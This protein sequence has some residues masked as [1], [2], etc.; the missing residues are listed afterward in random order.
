MQKGKLAAL[1]GVAVGVLA[2]VAAA[3]LAV[4]TPSKPYT[5]GIAEGYVT[6]PLLTV[7]DTVPETSDPSKQYQ[8]VGIPDGLGARPNP[9]PT[10]TVW[11]NHELVHNTLSRTTIGE[12]RDRGPIVSKYI[13]DSN[14][15]PISGERAYDEVYLENTFVGPAPTEANRTP[16]FTRFCSASLAGKAEGLDTDIYFANE[17]SGGANTFDGLGGLAVAITG[18]KAYGLPKLGHFAWENTLVQ[19][20]RRGKQVAM[21]GLED[22]PADLNP[23]NVNSQVYLYVGTKVKGSSSVLSRNG[24]DNGKLYVLAPVNPAVS[25]E[26]SFANGTIDVK[27]VQVPNSNTTE[28]C[29]ARGGQRRRRRVPLRAAR[30][31]GSTRRTPTTSSS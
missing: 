15:T 25:S 8:M 24:L 13:L 5:V 9:G 17:E 1:I 16:S 7:G 22:G 3:A 30:G 27:W 28:R 11:M 4:V 23:A 12:P 29:P 14:G 10:S 21:M 6:V 26:E 20:N 19:P 18:N 2:A 31:R